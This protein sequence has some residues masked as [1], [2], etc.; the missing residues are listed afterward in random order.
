M[1][2]FTIK[3]ND[4]APFL[5][6]TL[7]DFN[8]DAVDI[9]SATVVFRMRHFQGAPVALS[10]VTTIQQ[11]GD[12]DDGSLGYVQY[13]WGEG[14]L[15]EAGAYYAEWEVHFASGEIETFPNDSYIEILILADIEEVS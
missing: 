10:G 15:D 14:D 5:Q 12:G 8:G 6:Q 1:A 3:T 13:E 9:Q 2:D 4:T 7:V 11:N